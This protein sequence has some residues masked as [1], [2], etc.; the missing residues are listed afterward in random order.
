[1]DIPRRS[2]A[3]TQVRITRISAL[4][5]PI[6]TPTITIALTHTSMVVRLLVASLQAFS[7]LCSGQSSVLDKED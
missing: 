1:M 5:P 3:Q 2:V 7:V 4:T 6:A